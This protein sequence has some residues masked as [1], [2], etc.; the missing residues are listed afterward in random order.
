MPIK[1]YETIQRKYWTIEQAAN[2]LKTSRYTIT[3]LL[4][5]CPW[6]PVNTNKAKTIRLRQTHIDFFR[7]NISGELYIPC[8]KDR[9]W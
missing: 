3:K 9:E 5:K 4:K 2:D 8:R 6:I 1:K 7:K